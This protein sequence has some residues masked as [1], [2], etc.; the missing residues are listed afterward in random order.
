MNKAKH[1]YLFL[2]AAVILSSC[3]SYFSIEKRKYK[4]G[5]YVHQNIF[6]SKKHQAQEKTIPE[7]TDKPDLI[8]SDL[9][10]VAQVKNETKELEILPAKRT[11]VLSND[12]ALKTNYSLRDTLPEKKKDSASKSNEKSKS[13]KDGR[14]FSKLAIIGCLLWPLAIT[15]FALSGLG[16]ISLVLAYFGVIAFLASIVISII[17]IHKIKKY[18]DKYKGM[19]FAIAV[20]AFL[21]L[22]ILVLLIG[23]LVLFILLG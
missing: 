6:Q 10:A 5:F 21:L 20:F 8:S 16:D 15:L 22:A 23:A 18:R 4:D 13:I 19:G 14:K 7:Q 1:L 9:F 12:Y 17:A 11:L 2:F 3:S